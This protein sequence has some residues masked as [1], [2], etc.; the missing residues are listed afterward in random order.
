MIVIV[1]WRP[2]QR[3]FCRRAKEELPSTYGRQVK[4]CQSTTLPPRM[5]FLGTSSHLTS[6]P[7][8]IPYQVFSIA[9]SGSLI[10]LQINYTFGL[11]TECSTMIQPSMQNSQANLSVFLPAGDYLYLSFVHLLYKDFNPRCPLCKQ[12]MLLYPLHISHICLH[13]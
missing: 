4:G 8:L 5:L 1:R 9:S 6:L 11:I 3:V 10:S 13:T 7:G 12:G 2:S